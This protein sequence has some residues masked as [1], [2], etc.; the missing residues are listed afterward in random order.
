MTEQASRWQELAD[1]VEAL[2]LKLKLHVEQ[3]DDDQ[4]VRD[5]MGRLRADVDEAFKA[6]GNAVQDD[7]VREDVRE[8]G[9]LLTDALDTTFTRVGHQVRDLFA[10]QP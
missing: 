7:A 6:A 1:R 8:V 5:A 9:R 3:V 4:E 2:A 10:R